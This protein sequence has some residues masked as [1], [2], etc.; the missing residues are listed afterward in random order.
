MLREMSGAD[1]L[2][3]LPLLL[4]LLGL[5]C[6]VL[7]DP[8]IRRKHRRIMLIIVP[9]L[10]S[11]LAQSYVDHL[12]ERGGTMPLFCFFIL[13]EKSAPTGP[14]GCWWGSTGRST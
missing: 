11:L 2:A 5:T 4:Q 12:L 13:L 6:A 10:L 8:F 14:H 9:L 7:I 3:L 1:F